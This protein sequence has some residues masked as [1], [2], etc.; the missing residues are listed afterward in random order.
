[1]NFRAF[2]LIVAAVSS[3]AVLATTGPE[4]A[5]PL[6][7]AA[8]VAAM[9]SRYGGE[10]VAIEYDNAGD[11]RAH[12]HVEMRFPDTTPARVD[13]DAE[14]LALASHSAE[15]LATPATTLAGAV[16]MIAARIPGQ[17]TYAYFDA[18]SG[19]APH[20]DIDVRLHQGDVAQ[21]KVDP[22]TGSFGWRNPPVVAD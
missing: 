7:L 11:K 10:V 22:A 19:A 16:A 12:Y 21:L 20:Y 1:M 5:P 13:V 4:A 6:R 2:V 9:E 15:P 17:V 14:T 8:V 18:P 3:N